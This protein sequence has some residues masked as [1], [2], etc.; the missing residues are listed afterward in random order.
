MTKWMILTPLTRILSRHFRLENRSALPQ[1]A[2]SPLQFFALIKKC[3]HDINKL[4]FNRNTKFSNLPTKDS[5]GWCQKILV[6]AESKRADLYQ[7]KASRQLSDTSFWTFYA[8]SIKISLP[9]TP[10]KNRQEHC[11]NDLSHTAGYCQSSNANEYE[12][13]YIWTAEKDMKS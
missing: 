10:Q 2:T 12:R 7:K 8:K 3:R 11:F 9:L 1:R 13:S 5:R 6:S 4:E